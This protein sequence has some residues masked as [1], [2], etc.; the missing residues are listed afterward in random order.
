MP[1]S[2]YWSL[3]EISIPI[4]EIQVMTTI[5]V[6]PATVTHRFELAR[7]SAPISR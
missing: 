6:M 5:Q 1:S 3:A 4:H 2:R 7:L